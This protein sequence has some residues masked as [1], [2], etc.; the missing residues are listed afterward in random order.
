VLTLVVARVDPMAPT[1]LY[2]QLLSFEQH[3]SLQGHRTHDGPS[4][5]MTASRGCD[6]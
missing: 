2:T 1:K 4:S 5:A 3:T 6:Y